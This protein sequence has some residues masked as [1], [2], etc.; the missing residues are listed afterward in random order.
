MRNLLSIEAVDRAAIE[1]ILDRAESFAEVGR[2][3]IKKVPTLRGRTVVTLFY[4][5][6]T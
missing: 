2:R 5:S 3:D 1:A 4:E 6:S